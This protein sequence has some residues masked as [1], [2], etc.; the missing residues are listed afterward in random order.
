[1][2]GQCLIADASVVYQDIYRPGLLAC[3]GYGPVYISLIGQIDWQGQYLQLRV[4]CQQ[5]GPQLFEPPGPPGQ[6]N[7]RSGPRRELYGK[8][9]ADTR[10][11]AGDQDGAAIDWRTR[12]LSH[13]HTSVR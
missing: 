1:L 5:S 8:L 3:F 10:R 2:V 7:E 11:G 9:T 4:L 6:Q 12:I 13:D